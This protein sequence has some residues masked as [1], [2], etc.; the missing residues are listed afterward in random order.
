M[1]SKERLKA[2]L[3]S[4]KIYARHPYLPESRG[5]WIGL[6]I[7]VPLAG[8]GLSA[9]LWGWL[10]GNESAGTTI[11]NVGLIIAALTALPVAIWRGIVADKQAAAA[12]QQAEIAQ[13]QVSTSQQQASAAHRQVDTTFQGLRNER[14]QKGAEML[15]NERLS[16]RLGGIYALQRL[17][18]E[19]PE[20]YHIQIMRL[21]SAFVRNPTKDEEHLLQVSMKTGTATIR[22][23]VQAVMEAFGKRNQKALEI[24]SKEKVLI[25]LEGAYLHNWKY[26]ITGDEINLFGVHLPDANLSYATLWSVQLSNAILSNAILFKTMFWDSK[27]CSANM[28]GADMSEAIFGC[29]DT[30]LYDADLSGANLSKATGL[31]QEQLNQACAHPE[32]PPNLDG[33]RDVKTGE[34]LEWSGKLPHYYHLD[35][36]HPAE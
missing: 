9:G 18:E 7:A 21:F 35:P 32:H 20:E 13:V 8:I 15:G 26:V 19:H 28:H 5:F 2:I 22:E 31:T 23:D 27:L 1:C 33:A 17:A 29:S 10:N 4:A 12:R 16:V 24:E 36:R 11:R 34:Q 30:F 14:Y 25:N 6:S 3:N